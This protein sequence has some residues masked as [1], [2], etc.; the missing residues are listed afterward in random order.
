MNRA[1]VER[2]TAVEMDLLD[3]ETAWVDGLLG[4][5]RED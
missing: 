2:S 1:R 5:L 3:R 4:I